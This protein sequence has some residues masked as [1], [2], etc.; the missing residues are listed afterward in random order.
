VDAIVAL[1]K[2]RLKSCFSFFSKRSENRGCYSSA[3]K[4]AAKKL[5]FLLFKAF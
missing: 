5:L 3:I 2:W 1:S 4:M